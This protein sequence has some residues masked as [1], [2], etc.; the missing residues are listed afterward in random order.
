MK[1]KIFLYLFVESGNDADGEFVS[2]VCH[3]GAGE[4]C[5]IAVQQEG[6]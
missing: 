2:G 6:N 5:S 3:S 1:K 4:N